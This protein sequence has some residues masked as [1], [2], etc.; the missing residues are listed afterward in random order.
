MAKQFQISRVPSLLVTNA[1]GQ[2]TH[3]L[4]GMESI[5]S[6]IDTV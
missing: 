4:C 3:L 2:K 5:F 6:Q 1:E